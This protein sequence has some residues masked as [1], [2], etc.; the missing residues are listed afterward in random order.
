MNV[1]PSGYYQWCRGRPSARQKDDALLAARIAVEHRK[2]RGNYGA[3]RLVQE[4]RDQGIAIS[5]RRCGRLMREQG[6]KGRKR[7]RRRPRTTDSRHDRPVAPNR[8]KERPAP[9]GPD[10]VWATDITYLP[11]AEGYHFLAVILDLWSRRVVGWACSPTLHACLAIA[12]LKKAIKHRRPRGGLVHHSDRGSQ[13]V[14]AEYIK[15]LS[16]FGFDRSMS[17]R[18]NCYDNATMESFFSSL[19]TESE[20]ETKIPQTRRQAELAV[21]DYIETF[22]NPTRRHSS[23]GYLSPVAFEKRSTKNDIIAA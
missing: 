2:S 8:L 5:R 10:Q 18:A 6:I 3:P 19:K 1:S 4:L 13:Y 16:D 7:N 20:L 21:F 22:Y 17:R 12:A 14:D 15:I 23:I 9:S 11:T